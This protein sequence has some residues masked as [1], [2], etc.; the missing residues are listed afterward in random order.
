MI[1]KIRMHQAIF[2]VEIR[3]GQ[4]QQIR[5]WLVGEPLNRRVT[6]QPYLA[7][8]GK[9]FAR[10][11]RYVV[12]K[13][14]TG[15]GTPPDLFIICICR[16]GNG[17]RRPVIILGVAPGKSER[18]GRS[19]ADQNKKTRPLRPPRR[20]KSRPAG[21]CRK[22][23]FPVPSGVAGSFCGRW[24]IHPGDAIF[25]SCR[26]ISAILSPSRTAKF[27]PR[28]S[29]KICEKFDRKTPANGVR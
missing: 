29:G 8:R 15:I 19:D 11:Q 21:C 26:I 10:R 25:A 7:R 27:V 9:T 3:L 13:T 4:N 18:D 22:C 23:A 20:P 5:R 24:R 14:G 12:V 17:R 6:H 1:L 2:V 28:S 16:D